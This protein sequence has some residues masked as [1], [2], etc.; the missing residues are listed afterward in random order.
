[1][2]VDLEQLICTTLI[3]TP[4]QDQV[5]TPVRIGRDTVHVQ[6]ADKVLYIP[7]L[8]LQV[9]DERIVPLEATTYSWYLDLEKRLNSTTD[10]AA[11]YREEFP[12]QE[13]DEDVCILSNFYSRVFAH[14]IDELMKVI[15]LERHGFSGKYVF[16][17]A[18]AH[19]LELL[20]LG[21]IAEDRIVTKIA[22]PTV[23][24]SA[25]YTTAMSRED[26]LEYPDV[27]LA[28]RN[29]LLAAANKESSYGTRLWMTRG[30]G[31]RT[32]RR[33]LLVNEAEVYECLRRHRFEIVDPGSM[34]VADQIGTMRNAEVIS[35]PHGS[36]FIHSMFMNEGANVVECFSP[37]YINPSVIEVCRLLK[38]QYYM[39]VDLNTHNW[40]YPHGEN[41]RVNCSHLSLVLEGVDRRLQ[42]IV[43]HP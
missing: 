2:R 19:A 6:R 7:A 42:G 9:V 14:S 29:T 37:N 22:S 34:S 31:A 20:R 4:G 30:V 3:G 40:P 23:F 24:R 17:R 21:G 35:G 32:A 43:R 26:I 10:R 18:P 11:P 16:S 36:T 12:V 33:N 28:V 41:V 13:I 8:R 25:F 1:M 39:L 27:F 15:I 38:H 5:A